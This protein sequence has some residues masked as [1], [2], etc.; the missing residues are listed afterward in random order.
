[1]KLINKTILITGASSGIGRQTAIDLA[2]LGNTLILIGRNKKR[3]EEV[4]KKCNKYAVNYKIGT[5]YIIC[6]VSNE[7]NVKE[8]CKLVFEKYNKVD[9]LINNAGYG[10][11]RSFLK[12][13]TKNFKDMFDTNYFGIIYFTKAI[14]PSMLKRKYGHIV[15]IGSIVSKMAV[16]DMSAYCS[17][18]FAVMGLTESLRHEVDGTGVNVSIVMPGS[19]DTNFFKND[20]FKGSMPGKNREV[21]K[22]ITPKEVTDR[23]IYAIEHN[24]FEVYAPRQFKG[25]MS[26]KNNFPRIYWKM[27]KKML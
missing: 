7:K 17:T 4:K 22:T 25:V 6:D 12:T 2:K 21:I 3:L 5:S 26:L 9:V 8:A 13:S 1:M 27:I 18:K 15:N 24:R 23:I 10:E 14:L 20:T 16:P 19:T 11:K